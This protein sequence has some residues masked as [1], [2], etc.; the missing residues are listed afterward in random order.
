MPKGIDLRE[1]VET[2][3][4]VDGPRDIHDVHIWSIT[5]GLHALSGH[6]LI[7]D[8]LTSRSV[9]IVGRVESLLEQDFGIAHTTLQCESEYCA[10]SDVVCELA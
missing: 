2:V 10:N 9:D 7:E 3:G 1:V 6:L 5:S 8:Q 4:K